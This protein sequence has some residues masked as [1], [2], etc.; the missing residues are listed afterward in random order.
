MNLFQKLSKQK[1]NSV[2]T[3]FFVFLL[4]VSVHKENI[5][6]VFLS[7]VDIWMPFMIAYVQR[8]L[9]IQFPIEK[10]NY[11]IQYIDSLHKINHFD[12]LVVGAGLSGSVIAERYANAGMSVLII[13]K[14]S[15]IAGNCFDYTDNRTGIRV[16][17]YGA[18]LFHTNDQMIWKY[19]N[20]FSP[21]ARFDHRVLAY[22]DEKYVPVPVN[23]NTVNLLFEDAD[24]QN[25]HEMEIWLQNEIKNK[26]NTKPKNSEEMAISRVGR[27][28]YQKI[29]KPYTQKQWNMTAKNLDPSVTGRIPIYKNFDNRYFTD[30]YQGLPTH[31]YTSFVESMLG[32]T[33]IQVWLNQD[34]FDLPLTIKNY[35]KKFTILVLLTNM[36]IKHPLETKN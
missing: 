30:K 23:I 28:L 1:L 2:C 18:H 15:H 8:G 32:H 17:E 12:V 13:E 31:G 27:R 14:R 29:F 34:F 33:S 26:F 22:V 21:W 19:V 3:I 10:Q 5:Y 7:N 25:T 4:V 35:A 24:I 20:A 6:F 9:E 16:N 36:S 11:K